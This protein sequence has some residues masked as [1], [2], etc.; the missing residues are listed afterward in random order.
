MVHL[1][2]PSLVNPIEDGFSIGLSN[3]QGVIYS[4]TLQ[5]GDLVVRTRGPRSYVFKDATAKFG[6]GV[7]DGLFRVRIQIRDADSPPTYRFKLKALAELNDANNPVITTHV[8]GV[9]DSAII[10]AT[11]KKTRN[12]WKLSKSQA[13]QAIFPPTTC[14]AFP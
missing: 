7:R 14:N 4:A 13:T 11:W 3:E 6:G 1:A 10:R 9:E 12:G 2:A 5:P 8:F